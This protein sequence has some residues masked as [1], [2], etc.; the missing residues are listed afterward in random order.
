MR[1]TNEAKHDG[2]YR[3]FNVS[4]V[5]GSDSPS[6]KHF[7]CFYFVLDVDHDPHATAAMRAY[8][9]SC[10]KQLPEL[11][12]DLRR[13]CDEPRANNEIVVCD[14]DD[15][16]LSRLRAEVEALKAERLTREEAERRL[17]DEGVEDDWTYCMAR[18]AILDAL[19]PTGGQ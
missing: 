8:A 15:A 3:K 16:E 11:A 10:E 19:F 2:I 7:N 12:S 9:R 6:G 1:L 5:D 4:R 18:R 13:L 14:S 17:A